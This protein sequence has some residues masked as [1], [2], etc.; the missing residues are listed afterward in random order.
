MLDL[1]LL[2]EM[3]D[4][5]GP[6]GFEHDVVEV[7][8]KYTGTWSSKKDHMQNFFINLPTQDTT[9]PVVMLDSHSD[10]VGFMVQSVMHN[11]LLKIIPLGGWVESNVPAHTFIIK[12]SK[13]EYHR[14]VSTSKPPHFT[15]PEELKKPLDIYNDIQLDLGVTSRDQVFDVFGIEVG[16]PVMPEVKFDFNEKTGIMFGKAFDN[17]LG[18]CCILEVMKRLEGKETPVHVTGAIASQEEVG[19]RGAKVT[20]KV[21]KPNFSI[22]FEGTP[23]DDLYFDSYTVQGALG[24]GA[25]VRHRDAGMVSNPQFIKFAK[26][27]CEKYDIK[28]QYTVR[29]GG[30]TNA[31]AIHLENEGCP[32]LVIGV[33]SRYAHTLY[34]YAH[35]LDMQNAVYLAFA[36]IEIFT[37]EKIKEFF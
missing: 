27:M 17:R 12:N 21:V 14:A 19:L 7:A 36:F 4:A 25:Q 35:I 37:P 30:S 8:K 6:S 18:C 33:P 28:A 29:K 22:T 9:K 5:F 34:F 15:S 11:G 3:T 10:E 20:A 13:G 32:C 24:K 26:E 16:D 2:Q 1:K 31:G 23:A